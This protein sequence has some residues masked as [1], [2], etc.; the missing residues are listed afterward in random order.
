MKKDSQSIVDIFCKIGIF[1]LGLFVAAFAVYIY[2]PIVGSHADENSKDTEISL[3]VNSRLGIRVNT[4][5]IDLSGTMSSFVQ[6]DVDVDVATNSQFGYT[7]AIEDKDDDTNMIHVNSSVSDTVSSEFTGAMSSSNMEDNTWGFKFND[8]GFYA[9]PVAG[10]PVAIK[11]TTAKSEADYETT[12]VTFGAKIGYNLTAGDYEDDIK[13]TAYVNGVDGGPEDGTK[14]GEPGVNPDSDKMQSFDCS[15]LE[16]STSRTLID[17]RDGNTYT[18][19]KLA[20]GRCWMTQN[21]RLAGK[22]ISNADSDTFNTI[23]IPNNNWASST[24]Q[25]TKRDNAYT[26]VIDND[27]HDV[28]YNYAAATAGSIIGQSNS[29]QATESICPTGWTLPTIAEYDNLFSAAG[30]SMNSA[31]AA[32]MMAEPYNYTI[33]GSVMFNSITLQSPNVQTFYW[34]ATASDAYSRK[35]LMMQ[36]NYVHTGASSLYRYNGYP[37]RCIARTNKPYKVKWDLAGGEAPSGVSLLSNIPAG[38]SI[39]LSKFKPTRDGYAF[40]GWTSSDNKT[41]TGNETSVNLNTSSAKTI[42][43]TAGWLKVE[44]AQNFSCASFS[45][46]ETGHILDTRD[47]NVYSIARLADGRCW[48]TENLRLQGKTLTSTDTDIPSGT[49]SLPSSNWLSGI[50]NTYRDYDLKNENPYVYDTGNKAYG[51]L[52]NGDA[53]YGKNGALP[54]TLDQS[55]CPKGW[56]LPTVDE[57]RNMYSSVYSKFDGDSA[58]IS[59][60]IM[61]EPFH[62]ALSGLIE[63]KASAP[64]EVGSQ[65]HYRVSKSD[66]P[67]YNIYSIFYQGNQMSPNN[68]GGNISGFAIRCIAR[69]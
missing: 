14:P 26:Y 18:V 12:T 39:N 48:M 31:G 9:I 19:A 65:A 34:T 4:E 33:P 45:A 23:E 36:S 54:N 41:Y 6:G 42:K 38:V 13:F 46:T 25:A 62:A 58:S 55:I 8:N 53:A 5:L 32:I 1:S 15:T 37:V 50:T 21:L 24:N 40:T 51:V 10:S 43:L 56:T 67:Y 60:Y 35:S 22:T 2:S 52:Y 61:N 66:A 30:I 28:L 29:T 27:S 68:A 3:T 57:F 17:K 16:A 20:D 59:S 44:I 69:E 11:R 63:Y 47:G 7:L 64:K 49:F